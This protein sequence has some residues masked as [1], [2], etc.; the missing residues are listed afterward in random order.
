[1]ITRVGMFVFH[2]T[3]CVSQSSPQY[4]AE[5]LPEGWEEETWD[6]VKVHYCPSH[7]YGLCG[8]EIERVNGYVAANR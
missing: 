2:C 8:E 5:W 4:S 1:M 3:A 6:G 7:R